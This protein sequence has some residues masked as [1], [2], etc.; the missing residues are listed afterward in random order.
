MKY[1][2]STRL[3]ADPASI[4]QDILRAYLIYHLWLNCI[5]KCHFDHLQPS[6]FG[7]KLENKPYKPVWFEGEQFPPSLRSK[8]RKAS[9][10]G[11]FADDE[12]FSDDDKQSQR[13]KKIG[14]RR[15]RKRTQD[16]RQVSEMRTDIS[17]KNASEMSIKISTSDYSESYIYDPNLDIVDDSSSEDYL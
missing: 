8:R 3:P 4:K 6:Q 15:K 1:K 7:Y 12:R 17:D 10:D 14:A 9:T 16:D 5:D 13:K 11:N 2:T